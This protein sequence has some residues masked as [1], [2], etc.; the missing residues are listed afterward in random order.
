MIDYAFYRIAKFYYKWDGSKAITAILAI[1]GTQVMY[2]FLPISF[3]LK[4]IYSRHE[5]H[6]HSKEIATLGTIV[7]LAIVYIN[8]NKYKALYSSL[9]RRWHNETIEQ[10]FFRCIAVWIVMLFPVLGMLLLSIF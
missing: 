10:S 1:S 6:P 4:K 7:F 9:R 2:V 5:L 3:T 8:H